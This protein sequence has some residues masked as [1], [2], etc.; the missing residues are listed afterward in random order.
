VGKKRKTKQVKEECG[1]GEKR[2]GPAPSS[3]LKTNGVTDGTR[4][5]K[6][7]KERKKNQ[8]EQKSRREV[9][10]NRNKR[11]HEVPKNKINTK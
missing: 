8:N 6:T 7:T 10:L 9:S 1:A 5:K 3:K 4:G 2:G 11:T